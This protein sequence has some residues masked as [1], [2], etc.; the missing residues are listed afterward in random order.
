MKTLPE[1][2]EQKLSD[3]EYKRVRT[4]VLGMAVIGFVVIHLCGK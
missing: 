4:I 3:I 1:S 2:Q